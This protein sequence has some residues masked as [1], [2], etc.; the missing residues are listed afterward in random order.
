MTDLWRSH[1]EIEYWIP[2]HRA[3]EED[4]EDKMFAREEDEVLRKALLEYENVLGSYDNF[5]Q[6]VENDGIL[7][8]CLLD[9]ENGLASDD[10]FDQ[11]MEDDGI[12][13]NCLLDYESN[14]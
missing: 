10:N 12:L 7:L 1:W 3:D 11:E 13:L 9:Y 8:N 2:P 6:D 5:D 4:S 14:V